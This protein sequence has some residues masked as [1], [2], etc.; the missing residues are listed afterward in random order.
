MGRTARLTPQIISHREV[1]VWSKHSQRCVA[2]IARRFLVN[3]P[4]E[5]LKVSFSE[6]R[7]FCVRA[8]PRQSD[9]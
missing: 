2:I 5:G 1:V 8:I 7:F 4:C 9:R 3:L 6:N